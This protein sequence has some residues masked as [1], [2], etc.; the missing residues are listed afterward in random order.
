MIKSKK[1]SIALIIIDLLLVIG[2]TVYSYKTYYANLPTAYLMKPVTTYIDYDEDKPSSLETVTDS[3]YENSMPR[4]CLADDCTGKMK[5]KMIAEEEGAWGK[6]YKIKQTDV[7]Y[8]PVDSNSEYV[9]IL[10]RFDDSL[11]I[12]ADVDAEY[13]YDGME[14]KLQR[15]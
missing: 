13:V 4:T 8:W 5:I 10:W 7:L 15:R 3:M 2:A 9:V 6:S 11:P 1:I 12:A 14:V